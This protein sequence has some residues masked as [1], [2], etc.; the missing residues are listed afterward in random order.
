M[1]ILSNF[2]QYHRLS[3]DS[4]IW[5]TQV[6]L[7]CSKTF[8]WCNWVG[9]GRKRVSVWNKL[10]EKVVFLHEDPMCAMCSSLVG[11]CDSGNWCPQTSRSAPWCRD[12]KKLD[13]VS[14]WGGSRWRMNYSCGP[15]ETC[16]SEY[17]LLLE[18]EFASF[19]ESVQFRVKLPTLTWIR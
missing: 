16:T 15:V 12:Q 7:V 9:G 2:A 18:L 6:E 3:M 11:T 13:Q 1:L 5:A 8:N 19:A 17:C 4:I 14:L 10:N